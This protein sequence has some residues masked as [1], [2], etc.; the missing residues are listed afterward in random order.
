MGATL[1]V[2]RN[3]ELEQSL[4]FSSQ[5]AKREFQKRLCHVEYAVVQKLLIQPRMFKEHAMFS[6]VSTSKL[7]LPFPKLL[8]DESQIQA[9]ISSGF[10]CQSHDLSK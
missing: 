7:H 4:G 8:G 9:R 2:E 10:V 3:A 5:A 1:T 6:S